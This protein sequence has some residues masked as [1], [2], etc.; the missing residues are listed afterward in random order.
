[1]ITH[2]GISRLVCDADYVR[3]GP[4]EVIL[5]MGPISFDAST[6]EIWGS[7]LNGGRLVLMPSGPATL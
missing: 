7:L 5:Q 1:M 3:L 2:R 6:F 4:D